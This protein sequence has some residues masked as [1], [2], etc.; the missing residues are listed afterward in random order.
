MSFS[1]KR[2]LAVGIATAVAF[3]GVGAAPQAEARTASHVAQASS[4]LV[5]NPATQDDG[6]GGLITSTLGLAVLDTKAGAATVRSQLASLSAGAATVAGKPG[7]AANLAILARIM[8][9][10]PT[11]FGGQN[12]IQTVLDGSHLDSTDPALVGQVGDFGSAYGQALAIIA[13][14]RSNHRVPAATVTKLV[15]KLLEF[16][17]AKSG[18]FGYDFGGFVADPDSTALA[19]QALY[20]VK[21]HK[22]EIKKAV[23][24]AKDI[25]TKAGY[26]DSYSPVDSTSLMGS[27]LKLVGKSYTKSRTW[28]RKQQLSDGGFPA[29]LGGTSSNL[30]AT[31]NATFLLSG[32]SLAKA[33]YSLKGYSKSPRPKIIGAPMVGSTLT[34]VLRTWAPVPQ[35]K[36]QWLRSGKAVAGSTATTYVLTSADKGRRIRVKVTASGMGLKKHIEYSKR[37]RI[38]RP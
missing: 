11:T 17:D 38:V 37:T 2:L 27:T 30:L 21:H 10:D 8:H 14:K 20:L 19:I 36:I 22:P 24:W 26:W 28:L 31:S 4:W 29:S 6:Y 7:Q 5:A 35:V 18:A 13:L 34:V 33:S 23:A 15:T 32:E 1:L 16:R 3:V 25:R 12:L 9:L